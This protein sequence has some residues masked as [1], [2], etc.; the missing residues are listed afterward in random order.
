VGVDVAIAAARFT[1]NGRPDPIKMTR[2]AAKSRSAMAL[3]KIPWIVGR[4]FNAKR[5][6]KPRTLAK[7]KWTAKTKIPWGQMPV[8]PEPRPNPPALMGK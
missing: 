6:S 2:T 3:K 4:S 5:V 8:T 1:L 7:A